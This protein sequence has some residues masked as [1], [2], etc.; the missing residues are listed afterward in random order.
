VRQE[1]TG[2][3]RI[4]G[5]AWNGQIG[6]IYA[7]GGVDTAPGSLMDR[8]GVKANYGRQD[9]YNAM[10][11]SLYA[12]GKD[13]ASGNS[14]PSSGA[15]FVVIMGDGGPGFLYGLQKQ[16][17]PLHLHA[18]VIG[19]AGFSNGEDKCMG[20]PEWAKDPEKAKGALIA[21]VIR[22]G[23]WN[24]C[25][26]WAQ[27]HGLKIN[28]DPKTFDPNAIN[29]FQT[30]SFTEADQAYL[31]G[32]DKDH[33]LCEERPVVGGLGKKKVC[34]NGVATWTPGDV[35]VV[36][37]KGG[38]VGLL[39]TAENKA[40]MAATIITIDEWAQQNPATVTNFLQA[41]FNGGVRVAN[42]RDA[43]R[44]AA[45]LSAKVW[46]EQNGAYWFRYYNGVTEADP[47]TGDQV[48]LGGSQAIGLATN[49][50]Y[51]VPTSGRSMYNIVYDTF[52]RIDTTFYP[53]E[54]PTCPKDVVDTS[55][56]EA[57]AAKAGGNIG[58]G[59]AM[60]T[61]SG[62]ENA[63]QAQA[64]YSINF[65]QGSDVVSRD[66]I[67]V[68]EGILGQITSASTLAVV[69]EGYTSSEGG[70]TVNRPLSLR[71]AQAVKRWL[72]EHAPTGVITD[73]RV[74]AEGHGSEQLV[75]DANGRENARAS[76]RT[77]IR[78]TK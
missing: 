38:L 41:V 29:F 74:R 15:H 3:L 13:F 17:D 67:P 26:I 76:R 30:N 20:K 42:D 71:R 37:G 66:S 55:F 10:A 59:T 72:S 39:S 52:C 61:F 18:K 57:I 2:P 12:F 50:Q 77:V 9:D 34:V 14:D 46:H 44:T 56:I 7:N 33:G 1:N 64:A 4:L 36:E 60:G 75:T 48:K 65:E 16:L 45:D 28:P 43:L 53:A 25:V 24:I 21:G 69:I 58:Q 23:D 6:A 31:A 40:Q 78:F 68:L 49:V 8:G 27:M 32:Q 70:D 35:E 73:V 51:F 11:G 19:A 62:S 22:D 47:Q 63:T 54:M 5:I